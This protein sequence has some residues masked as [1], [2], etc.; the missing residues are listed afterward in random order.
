MTKVAFL[1]S[2][3]ERAIRAAKKA[4]VR[5]VIQAGSVVVTVIP[6]IHRSEEVDET[7]P[8]PRDPSGAHLAP[9]GEEQFDED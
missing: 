3:M 5:A 1:Q 9:D 4:G 7:Q 6:D 2:D 8:P